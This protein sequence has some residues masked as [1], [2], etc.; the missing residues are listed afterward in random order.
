MNPE[1]LMKSIQTSQSDKTKNETA[2]IDLDEMSSAEYID[3]YFGTRSFSVRKFIELSEKE[4]RRFK[5]RNYY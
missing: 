5:G 2:N 1:D 3:K 4:K